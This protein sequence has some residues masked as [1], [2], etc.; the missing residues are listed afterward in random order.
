MIFSLQNNLPQLS[1]RYSIGYFFSIYSF[2]CDAQ[3]TLKNNKSNYENLMNQ[4]FYVKT[5]HS[6]FAE[7]SLMRYISTFVTDVP[8]ILDINE[9]ANTFVQR[10]GSGA[11]PS[12]INFNFLI[13]ANTEIH[14]VSCLYRT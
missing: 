9:N 12:E 5:T 3:S 14:A 13:P 11:N 8:E 6:F 1:Q 2:N 4:P 10:S 7:A